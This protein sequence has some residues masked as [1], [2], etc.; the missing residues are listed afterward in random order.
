MSVGGRDVAVWLSKKLESPWSAEDFA[1][2]VTDEVL[3]AVTK[4][5]SVLETQAKLGLMF[6]FVALRS[7]PMFESIVAHVRDIFDLAVQDPEEWVRVCA[8]QLQEILAP[9]PRINMLP[10]NPHVEETFKNL[11][12]AC[13]TTKSNDYNKQS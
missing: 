11:V 3:V 13:E 8:S 2:L 7:K 5:F 9:K 1:Y 12:K 4:K 6:S 10:E